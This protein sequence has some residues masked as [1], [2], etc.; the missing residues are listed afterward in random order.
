MESPSRPRGG[1]FPFTGLPLLVVVAGL[2][3]CFQNPFAVGGLFLAT[4]SLT[5]LILGSL[6]GFLGLVVFIIYLGGAIVL[7]SYCFMLSPLQAGGD[8]VPLYPAPLVLVFGLGGPPLLSSL[9]D[10][11]WVLALLLLLGVLLF[12]V[13]VRVVENLDIGRGTMRVG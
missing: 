7:F 12:V 3:V 6:D 4:L 8:P 5:A 11:Y 13:I 10:F 1:P 2:F 9:F